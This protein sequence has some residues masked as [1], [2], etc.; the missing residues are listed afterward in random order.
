MQ[1]PSHLAWTSI[2]STC[3]LVWF[4]D[5]LSALQ[6]SP[7][8]HQT[9]RLAREEGSAGGQRHTLPI[10]Y[11]D[12]VTAVIF[13]IDVYFQPLIQEIEHI[14]FGFGVHQQLKHHARL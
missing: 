3:F 6:K 10:P 9:W 11:C 13:Q 4:V 7:P 8:L 14:T 12:I 5:S 2:C 1:Q